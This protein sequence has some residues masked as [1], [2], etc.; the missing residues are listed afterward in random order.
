MRAPFSPGHR[1]PRRV[2]RSLTDAELRL[3]ASIE[4]RP[5]VNLRATALELG[6]DPKN[7]WRMFNRLRLEGAIR[8]V[9]AIRRSEACETLTYLSIRWDQPE[10]RE[11]LERQLQDDPDVHGVVRLSGGD[12][13]R[14]ES[15]HADVRAA[16]AWLQGLL[17]SPG[18]IRGRQAFLRTLFDRRAY[19]AALLGESGA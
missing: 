13:Y 3:V 10:A 14:I 6:L 9:A 5:L 16:S 12:D 2:A 7:F 1:R 4:G 8:Q 18:V 15:H 17:A 11:R 19:A